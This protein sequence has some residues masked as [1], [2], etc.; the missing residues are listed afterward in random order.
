M[1]DCTVLR[2]RYVAERDRLIDEGWNATEA[3]FQAY[4]VGLM[5]YARR[6]YPIITKELFEIVIDDCKGSH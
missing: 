3:T 5:D 2:E 6:Y 4:A 1:V